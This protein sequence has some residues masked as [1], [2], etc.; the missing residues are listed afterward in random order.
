MAPFSNCSIL[1]CQVLAVVTRRIEYNGL[2]LLCLSNFAHFRLLGG[3]IISYHYALARFI[4]P[5]E[6]SS[7]FLLTWSLIFLVLTAPNTWPLL[8]P[9]FLRIPFPSFY[10]GGRLLSSLLLFILH[11]LLL[12]ISEEGQ[13]GERQCSQP[14]TPLIRRFGGEEIVNSLEKVSPI[15]GYNS[16]NQRD[17]YEE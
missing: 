10:F 2:H 11:A 12:T 5:K 9:L 3:V 4:L 13:W 17:L 6:S 1:L 8:F 7:L 14:G 15:P 16:L